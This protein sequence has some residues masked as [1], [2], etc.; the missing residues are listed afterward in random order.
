MNAISPERRPLFQRL[1]RAFYNLLLSQPMPHCVVSWHFLFRRNDPLVQRH[2]EI[3]RHARHDKIPPPLWFML[4]SL[5]WLRWAL[6]HAWLWTW[7]AVATWGQMVSTREGIGRPRQFL[8]I[9]GLALLHSIDPSDAYYYRLY[10]PA[11]Q[12]LLWTYVYDQ[13]TSAFH[14]MRSRALGDE[15]AASEI[16]YDK[17]ALSRL[18]ALRG[19][20][21]VP[22]LHEV[23]RG[24][25]MDFSPWLDAYPR[26]FCKTRRGARAEGAFLVE[27]ST[28]APGWHIQEFA[29]PAITPEAAGAFLARCGK[30]AA[31]L[32]QECLE[33]HPALADLA[34]VDRAITLRVIT[35]HRGSAIQVGSAQLAIPVA[36]PIKTHH[37]SHAFL[38]VAMQD[39]RLT[40]PTEDAMAPDEQPQYA[41]L[42]S[43]LGGRCIP[44]WPTVRDLAIAA[45]ASF[46]TI[47]AIAWDFV[48]TASG[49]RLL[50]GNTC[51]GVFVPQWLSGGLVSGE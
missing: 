49:P 10:R 43:L 45:H 37:W 50:E 21:V 13:E 8:R 4:N 1:I 48:L 47:H 46:P 27:R 26:L 28:A 20:P 34:T 23:P 15:R 25:A 24:V 33:D 44:D 5:L 35:E 9:L 19:L 32:I 31:Y 30:R 18:L 16:L 2:L 14:R 17:T 51:W 29:G 7:R 40:P 41:R 36:L 12:S 11:R 42:A 6:F 3:S 38:A 39:G 22:I